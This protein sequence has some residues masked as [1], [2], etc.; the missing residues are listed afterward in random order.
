MEE[1]LKL[2]SIDQ[3]RITKIIFSD[4]VEFTK[5]EEFTAVFHDECLKGVAANAGKRMFGARY[6][7]GIALHHIV[8]GYLQ[9]TTESPQA[10][11][12]RSRGLAHL[13]L[14]FEIQLSDM[15][16][17]L[18]N[19]INHGAYDS[20]I[21]LT[22]LTRSIAH[23]NYKLSNW[24]AAQIQVIHQLKEDDLRAS[25]L[26]DTALFEHIYLLSKCWNEKRWAFESEANSSLETYLPLWKTTGSEAEMQAAIFD[27]AC[28]HL[29]RYAAP[30]LM[31]PLGLP[32]NAA[33]PQE[34][35]AWHHLR[36]IVFSSRFSLPAHPILDTTVVN[37]QLPLPKYDDEWLAHVRLEAGKFYGKHWSE[38]T[39]DW[40]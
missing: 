21:S 11:I 2:D 26:F 23:G 33:Y 6:I 13:L 3:E 22:G 31:S 25:M 38:F 27:A 29:E 35:L 32:I 18:E 28:I 9:T 14:A 37:H 15:K 20:Q 4:L 5:T 8:N 7:E 36:E 16:Y 34:I 1:K 12:T 10:P 24:W 19:K 17:V 40:A 39:G 30:D